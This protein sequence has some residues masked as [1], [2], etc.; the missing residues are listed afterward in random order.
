MHDKDPNIPPMVKSAITVPV[1]ECQYRQSQGMKATN[2]E[3]SS[4]GA[5]G[6]HGW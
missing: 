3:W 4:Y 2:L 1:A 5:A 6:R